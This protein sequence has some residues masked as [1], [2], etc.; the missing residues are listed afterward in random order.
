M[1]SG[2]S[3]FRAADYDKLC[4]TCGGYLFRRPSHCHPGHV[5]GLSQRLQLLIASTCSP[6]MVLKHQVVY[7]APLPLPPPPSCSGEL[8][9]SLVLPD[10]LV[11]LILSK[12]TSRDLLSA[13]LV[14]RSWNRLIDDADVTP[15]SVEVAH[16]HI[17]RPAFRTWIENPRHSKGVR[18]S[19]SF[20]GVLV[21]AEVG[22]CWPNH[23]V[24]VWACMVH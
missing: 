18:W 19:P 3:F 16:H 10:H 21:L 13:R 20:V 7:L 6:H 1:F 5:Q 2:K 4:R 9:V 12:L 24:T 14:C 11:A 17:D 15:W 8:D 22:C 23:L